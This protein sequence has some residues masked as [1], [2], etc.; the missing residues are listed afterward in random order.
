M[1]YLYNNRY[2]NVNN[3][4]DLINYNNCFTF[5]GME[6]LAK[7]LR[8]IREK[9]G[10]TQ[11]QLAEKSGV[12]QV[13]INYVESGRNKTTGRL[14]DIAR[15]LHVNP[16]WLSS[17]EGEPE[18]IESEKGAVS[19]KPPLP[20]EAEIREAL[21]IKEDLI[22]VPRYNVTASMGPGAVVDSEQVVDYLSF[23]RSWIE[24]EHFNPDYLALINSR[25]DSMAPTINPG[26]LL[27]I[28]HSPIDRL[29]NGIYVLNVDGDLFAKRVE[30]QLDGSIRI[31]S[32][33][34]K[35]PP[36]VISDEDSK[37]LTVVG[38][39]VWAGGRM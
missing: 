5:S 17:G 15:A 8:F 20:S 38:R 11:K 27:L 26:D 9:Q 21:R 32:D 36:Q 19:E 28:D 4:C 25:G 30:R 16:V 1:S 23:K 3:N 34:P 39:V 29:S 18:G 10:L 7:R 12:S 33:N 14:V 2:R 35:Y 37:K 13:T 24:R 31:I 22:F 6:T